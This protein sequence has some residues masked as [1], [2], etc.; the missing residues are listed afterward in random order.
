MASPRG[1]AGFTLLELMIALALTGLLTLVAYTSLNLTIKAMTRDQAAGEYL[2]GLRVGQTFLERSLAS[3]VTGSLNNKNYFTGDATEMRFFTVV[4]LE[5]Y[6]LGGV[7]HWRVLV[8]HDDAGKSVVA[9]EQTKNVNWYRDPEGVETRQVLIGNLTS[10]H[11]T[12]GVGAEEFQT[13]DGTKQNGL[14]DWVKVTLQP[15]GHQAVDLL[16]PIHVATKTNAPK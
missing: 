15:E 10:A 1:N 3:A 16:I 5:A 14:P 13:W 6:N 7:F 2:Q 9:V 12:Y 4:P 8:G 11:F